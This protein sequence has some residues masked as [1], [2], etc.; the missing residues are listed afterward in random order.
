MRIPSGRRG[1]ETGRRGIRPHHSLGPAVA[2]IA[3]ETPPTSGSV[4]LGVPVHYAEVDEL[5]VKLSDGPGA[6]SLEGAGD[7]RRARAL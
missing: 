4:F 7:H 6:S 1:T 5:E 3:F 2:L